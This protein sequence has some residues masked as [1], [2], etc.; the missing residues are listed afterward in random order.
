MNARQKAK[1]YK[2]ELER[3]R[4]IHNRWMRGFAFENNTR[5]IVTIRVER[6]FSTYAIESLPHSVITNEMYKVLAGAEE[7]KA[8]VKFESSPDPM[9]DMLRVHASVKVVMPDDNHSNR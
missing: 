1:K 9:G 5:E 7:F 4:D 2:R 6:S 8:A 3:L